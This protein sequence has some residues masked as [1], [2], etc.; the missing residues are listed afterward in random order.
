MCL[1]VIVQFDGH[2]CKSLENFY[3]NKLGFFLLHN[4]HPCAIQPKDMPLLLGSHL[5]MSFFCMYK[6]QGGCS[7]HLWGT[8]L[9]L[10]DILFVM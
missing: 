1:V 7:L 6:F 3:S 2:F 5:K 4:G 9:S 10:K 8:L